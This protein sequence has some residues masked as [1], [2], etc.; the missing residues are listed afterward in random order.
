MGE[1]FPFGMLGLMALLFGAG[2]GAC[3]LHNV[4][5][6]KRELLTERHRREAAER[7]IGDHVKL[8]MEE[9]HG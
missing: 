3:Y 9:S 6:F 2:Y 5:Y 4:L 8:I 7:R 1:P